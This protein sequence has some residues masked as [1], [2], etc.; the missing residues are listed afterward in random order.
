MN[1]FLFSV[2]ALTLTAVSGV[3]AQTEVIPAGERMAADHAPMGI[4]AGSF[5]VIPKVELVETYNDNIY[6]SSNNEESDFVT[7]VKPE[8]SVRSNWSR[9][10]LNAKAGAEVRKFADNSEEDETNYNV[11]MDGRVDVLRDTSIGGGVSYARDHEDR[12]NPNTIGSPDEPIEY[13]TKIAR[14]GAYRGLGRANA[15]FDSEVKQLEYDNGQTAAGVPLNNSA[16]DRNEYT[17]T[18]RLGYQI[19]SRFEAFVKG[20]IDSRVYDDKSI[21]R[22]SHGQTY[23]AGT[24]FDISGKTRG[25]VYAGIASRNYT[26]AARE[27]IDEP[28]WGGK[29]TWNAT[30]LTSVIASVDRTIEETTLAGASGFVNTDYRVGVE[31]ALTRD[32][33]LKGNVG[34]LQADYQGNGANRDDE[35]YTAGA[36]I[37]YYLSRCFKAGLGYQ[38]T[39][40]QSNVAGGDY[41]RNTVMLRL[42]ATY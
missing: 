4:R 14:I 32:I 39:N 2:S 3:Y 41:G 23:T 10:A 8:V 6:A 34:Y 28:V 31:H 22:S 13:T 24:T 20:A 36:G 15:R 42:G 12:G 1:K 37:D 29:V 40:R 38:Y 33:L 5:L 30:D 16:R 9:H 26:N 17:Q 18:L 27:D 25:E 35:T 19:D 11:A 7:S 21:A